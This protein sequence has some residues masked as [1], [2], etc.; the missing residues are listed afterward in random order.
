M[1]GQNIYMQFSGNMVQSP[2]KQPPVQSELAI[3]FH[4]TMVTVSQ[5]YGY[6]D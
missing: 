3:K 2:L 6:A 1:T 4:E 5:V